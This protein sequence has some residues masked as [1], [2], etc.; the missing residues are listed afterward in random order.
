M[1]TWGVK[2]FEDDIACDVRDDY[3]DGIA[4]GE[5]EQDL[6]RRLLKKWRSTILDLE[7]GPVFWLALAATQ[8]ELGRLEGDVRDRALEI[9]ESG[10]ELQRWR[11]EPD[12]QHQRQLVLEKL[13]LQLRSPPP[14]PKRLRRPTPAALPMQIGDVWSYRL[15]GR[16]LILLQAVH[17]HGTSATFR[18]PQWHGL[19]A[20]SLA[21]IRGLLKQR[22]SIWRLHYLHQVYEKNAKKMPLDRLRMLGRIKPQ[23]S[24]N[25]FASFNDWAGFERL[26]L[27]VFGLTRVAPAKRLSHDLGLMGYH[28]AVWPRR[29]EETRAAA[30]RLFASYASRAWRRDPDRPK[31]A[32]T[33]ALQ[34]FVKEA[35]AAYP[36]DVQAP[37]LKWLGDFAAKE[38]CVIMGI[39]PG[40]EK[41]MVPFLRSLAKQHGLTFYDPQKGKLD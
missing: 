37:S 22:P 16:T 4:A 34:R 17:V 1:G 40:A 39:Q 35:K 14:K 33:P 23:P 15:Q 21:V 5:D 11:E 10:A 2:L 24:A 26:M 13:A 8:W 7:E 29:P 41:S 12:Y 9:I 27:E 20:P 36:Y 18:V 3:R 30:A 32:V 6:T 31:F 28:V 19:A 38:G 25:E